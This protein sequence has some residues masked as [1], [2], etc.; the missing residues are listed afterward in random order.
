MLEYPAY[1]RKSEDGSYIAE[2]IDLPEGPVAEGTDPHAALEN[3]INPAKK[4]LF[5]SLKNNNLPQPSNNYDLPIIRFDLRQAM[6]EEYGIPSDTIVG[7][8]EGRIEM[9]N[10]SW[11]NHYVF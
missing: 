6:N 10:Y 9:L 8:S 4:A 1:V 3:L 5:L 2:L 7:N 11:T